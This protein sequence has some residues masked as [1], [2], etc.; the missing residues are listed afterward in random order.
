MLIGAG[1]ALAVRKA[2]EPD[3]AIVVDQDVVRAEGFATEIRK[4]IEQDGKPLHAFKS[5]VSGER[6]G[7]GNEVVQRDGIRRRPIRSCRAIE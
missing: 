7:I 4:S 1:W 3:F 5:G 6:P 2:S